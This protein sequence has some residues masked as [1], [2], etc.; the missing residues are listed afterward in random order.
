MSSIAY[1][2]MSGDKLLGV[3]GVDISLASLGDGLAKLKP[4]DT[5][6]VYLLSQSGKWLVAPIPEL[7]LKEYDGEGNDVVKNALAS[8]KPG[9]VSNLSYD[10]NEPF[11]RLVYPFT[12]SGVNTSWVVLVDVPRT[13]INAPVKDQTYMMI[14]GG[15][16]VLGAVLLGLYLAVR[17]FVQK[18]L[19]ALVR[20]SP[21][22]ATA[23]T[24]SR[25][26]ARIAPTKPAKSPR[27]SKASAISLPTPSAWRAKPATSANRPNASAIAR[28]P[29]VPKPA[30][31]SATSSPASARACRT[32]RPA[33]SLS[34][35]PTIS[36]ANTL[37]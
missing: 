8:G 26:P 21:T 28:K 6:R 32:C 30:P 11:D 37:S 5:G 23:T 14:V 20:T 15:L 13:A 17:G 35:S 16:V 3:T 33:I 27:R 29:S 4:F 10:G 12:L 22:S 9:I 7:L 36:P 31:F 25:L 34:A 24:Q 1:P 19:A 18:P 2:V